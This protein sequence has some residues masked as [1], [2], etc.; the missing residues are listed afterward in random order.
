MLALNLI[1][2]F[3]CLLILF[4]L[5]S[6]LKVVVVTIYPGQNTAVSQKNR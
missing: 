1:F 6:Q 5:R 3:H 2:H 4:I